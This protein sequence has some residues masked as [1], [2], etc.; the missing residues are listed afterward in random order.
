M[1]DIIMAKIKI[2][3]L[4]FIL[5]LYFLIFVNFLVFVYLI[6]IDLISVIFDLDHTH[7]VLMLLDIL[8]HLKFLD[9]LVLLFTMKSCCY[10]IINQLY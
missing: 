1:D 9:Y 6:F 10:F 2:S 4:L 3:I 8:F 5:F 7:F